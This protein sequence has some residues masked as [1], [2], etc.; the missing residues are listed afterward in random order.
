MRMK[1]TF[2]GTREHPRR[3]PRQASI[4]AAAGT[5]RA[6]G[7]LLLGAATLAGTGEAGAQTAELVTDRPDQT[8]SATV[9]PRGLLQVE[10]GYRFTRDGGAGGHAGPGTLLRVGLG[11]RTELRL[12]HA[13]VVGGEG[14]R[15]AGDSELGAKINLIPR[16]DGWRPELALLGGLSLP[17]GDHGFSSDGADP[18]FLIAFAH[19]LRPRLALG[20]NAGAAWESSPDRPDRDAFIVYSLALGVSLTDRLGTFLEIFGDRQLTGPVASRTSVDGGLTFLLTEVLQLDFSVGRGLG[21]AADD[22]FVG[23]GLSLRL[24]R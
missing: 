19:E 16:A 2:A 24:P 1:M 6:L 8:E 10:T 12:G 5:G 21:A 11:G 18:S 13:G 9:V 14:R 3:R 22:L 17:T 20:Y 15:G 7:V 4:V 23:T